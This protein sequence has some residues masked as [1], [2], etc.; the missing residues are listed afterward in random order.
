MGLAGRHARL[1]DSLKVVERFEADADE[2]STRRRERGL[3]KSH[4]TPLQ[5]VID[6]SIGRSVVE[7]RPSSQLASCGSA[8]LTLAFWCR[9]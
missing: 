4:S 3:E 2:R 7:D 9:G 5:C 6:R 1:R 8:A